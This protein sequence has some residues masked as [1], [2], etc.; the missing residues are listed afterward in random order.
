MDKKWTL[1]NV[2]G[3]II[4]IISLICI[5]V[6]IFQEGNKI[7]L[8]IGLAGVSVNFILFMLMN[9]KKGK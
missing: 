8:I 9:R 1:G 3:M 4:G 2:I 7:F 6:S 5:I